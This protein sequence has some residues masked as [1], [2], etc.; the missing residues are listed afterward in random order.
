[1]GD[2]NQAHGEFALE[3]RQQIHHLRLDGDVQGRGR[4]VRDDQ[5]G[6]EGERHRDH[7]A[8]AHAAGELVRVV[9][10][11]L[12]GRGNA[13]P[14]HQLHGLATGPLT[15]HP[16]VDLE[17]LPELC[18]DGEDRVQRGQRVLEDHR[19]LR[20][21]DPAPFVLAQGEQIAPLE[22]D[23]A[24][25]DEP[26]R[27][28]EDAHHGL[29]GD[30]LAGARLPEHRQRLARRHAVA[31]AVDGLRHTVP[32]AELDPQIAHVQQGR[33]RERRGAARGL[34][35]RV[36]VRHG[37]APQRNLG[38][39]ASRTA[40]PSMMNAS[41]VMLSAPA[42]HSSMCGALRMYVEAVEMS[43]PQETVGGFRPAPR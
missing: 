14:L 23:L 22:E 15:G 5:V 17:H 19:H 20:A 42:G 41:T 39:R 30:G 11:P 34:S 21:T 6:A 9:A 10:H 36:L 31:D 18:P 25:G 33:V 38:S 7:D 37:P 40:S 4:L 12:P 1:M 28:V 29:C 26:R 8:L 3:L 35:G 32:G 24:A 13:D 43:M 27:G 2:Q 16:L